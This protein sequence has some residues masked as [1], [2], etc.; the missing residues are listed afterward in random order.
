MITRNHSIFRLC[1]L[2]NDLIKNIMQIYTREY[3]CI[4]EAVE[5]NWSNVDET[6]K[7]ETCILREISIQKIYRTFMPFN[8]EP[9]IKPRSIDN[10]QK[11]RSK[12]LLYIYSYS[13]KSTKDLWQICLE[14]NWNPSHYKMYRMN[15]ILRVTKL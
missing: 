3:I 13:F 14:L 11:N 15:H 7:Y 4:K 9:N 12:I 8:M 2:S 10:V 1:A 5:L 6:K